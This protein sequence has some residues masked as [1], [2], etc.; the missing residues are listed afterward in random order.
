MS[1]YEDDLPQTWAAAF[2]STARLFML[3]IAYSVTVFALVLLIV[4]LAAK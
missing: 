3:L 2:Y 4:G 1:I